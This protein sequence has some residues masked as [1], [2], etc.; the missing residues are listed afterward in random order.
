MATYRYN[1]LLADIAQSELYWCSLCLSSYMID[2]IDVYAFVLHLSAI[3]AEKVYSVLLIKYLR[4]WLVNIYRQLIDAHNT[5][6][7]R[8]LTPGYRGA[9]RQMPKFFAAGDKMPQL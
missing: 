7:C 8:P 5:P 1:C 4:N 9:A 3:Y 2:G 6:S